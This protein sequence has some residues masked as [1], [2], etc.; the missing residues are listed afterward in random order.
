MTWGLQSASVRFGQTP[1]L[2]DVTFLL[3]PSTVTVV[4][5]GDG[6]GKSTCLRAL[7]GLVALSTGEAHRPGRRQIGY[8]PATGGV[9][10][11][12]TVDEN[13]AFS[14]GVYGERGATLLDKSSATLERFGLVDAHSRLG[15]HLSGGMQRKLALGMALLHQPALLVLDEPTTGIDPLS[16]SEMWRIISR[17]AAG[18]AAVIVTTTYVDEAQ[19]ASSVLLLEQGRVIAQ[20]SPSSIVGAIGG[21]LGVAH[22]ATR[23]AGLSW[24]WGRAWRVWAPSGPLPDGVEPLQPEFE[25]AVVIASMADLRG[26]Q[27]DV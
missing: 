26:E 6:A 4:V 22:S 18:G 14:G 3:E 12:L 7:V 23:P 25:D 11:D 19:R 1:A 13:L 24:R 20:G 9:Y 21:T 2:T 17:A 27:L 5:G 15:G 16:R 10:P 8:V